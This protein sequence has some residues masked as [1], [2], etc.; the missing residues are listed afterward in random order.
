MKYIGLVGVFVKLILFYIYDAWRFAKSANLNGDVF[1]SKFR[2]QAHI[3]R[4]SHS[5]E[6]G[7]ALPEVKQGFGKDKIGILLTE[8]TRYSNIFGADEVADIALGIIED[9]LA[10]HKL[11][12]I[13]WSPFSMQVS[14]LRLAVPK[15]SAQPT[16]VINLTRSEIIASAPRDPEAFFALRR[17]VRQ[18]DPNPIPASSIAKAIE[19]AQ[20]CPSVCN[21][22]P[23]KVYCYTE[24]ED[25]VKILSLQDGNRG[26]GVDGSVVFVITADLNAFYKNGERNQG[27]VD[28]GIFAMSLAFSL[29]SL[30]FGS[31]MLNWSMG[32]GRDIAM[33]RMLG[34]ADSEVIVTLMVAGDLPSN[35]SVAASPRR[36]LS[37][38]LIWGKV[39]AV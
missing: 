6:K 12:G 23:V 25:R 17:S 5:L 28:G 16:G 29:H 15:V 36:P 22:Q 39:K 32:A 19:M 35:F 7:M 27:F 14:N 3:L 37:N 4:I 18:F 13:D 20:R 1:K 26:F 10:F 11:R 38:V 34:I 24:R 8:I 21:R 30:G 31:C 2:A 9:T 33:R